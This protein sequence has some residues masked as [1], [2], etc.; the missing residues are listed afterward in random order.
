MSERTPEEHRTLV[1]SLFGRPGVAI[2]CLWL[3]V[4]LAWLGLAIAE[5]SAF[6]YFVAALWLIMGGGMLVVALNDRAERNRQRTS[7]GLARAASGPLSDRSEH[8]DRNAP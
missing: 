6:R 7:S 1:R 3:G 4:G 2:S 8:S 5:P